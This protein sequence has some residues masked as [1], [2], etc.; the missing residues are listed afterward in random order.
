MVHLLTACSRLYRNYFQNGT[1]DD[2]D[3]DDDKHRFLAGSVDMSWDG[4][5]KT[6]GKL[7]DIKVDGFVETVKDNLETVKSVCS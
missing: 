7:D 3:F 5:K 4:V 6:F 1:D 2:D